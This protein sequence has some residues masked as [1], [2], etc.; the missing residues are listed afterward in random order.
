MFSL[1][2]TNDKIKEP[3]LF[4]KNRSRK[5][6]VCCIMYQKL[7]LNLQQLD[8]TWCSSSC[9]GPTESGTFSAIAKSNKRHTIATYCTSQFK[10][11]TNTRAGFWFRLKRM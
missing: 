4:H 6:A 3:L 9:S 10:A 1:P 7:R 5:Y 11:G 8:R 2:N